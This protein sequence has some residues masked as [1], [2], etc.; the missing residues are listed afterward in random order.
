MTNYEVTQRII[1]SVYPSIH[2]FT[3]ATKI[4]DDE[5]YETIYTK[6]ELA[7]WASFTKAS[8]GPTIAFTLGLCE[9]VNVDAWNEE[10]ET[11]R[12]T[13]WAYI[14][15]IATGDE[16]INTY[17]LEFAMCEDSL[18]ARKIRGQLAEADNAKPEEYWILAYG[19]GLKTP[20]LDMLYD[21]RTYVVT[22]KSR[23][24]SNVSYEEI[25]ECD[26]YDCIIQAM[27]KNA[28]KEEEEISDENTVQS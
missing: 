7:D 14:R 10:F 12:G 25:P 4:V 13:L 18:D 27:Q 24:S 23:V 28:K 3:S 26:V 8:V 1:P 16:D 2:L 5:E 15:N 17:S 20:V 6:R 11:V 21:K 19:D 9:T 22:V